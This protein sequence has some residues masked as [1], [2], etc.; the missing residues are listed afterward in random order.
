MM[1]SMGQET[2]RELDAVLEARGAAEGLDF[3]IE[4]FRSERELPLLF[5]ARLMRKRLEL[6]LPLVQTQ[7]PGEFPEELRAAYERAMMEVA[8]EVGNGYLEAGNIPRAWPYFRAI[9]EPGP[10]VAALEKAEPGGDDTDALI[11]IAFE[12]GVHPARGLQMIMSQHGMCRALTSF[13]MHQVAKDRE[14]CIALL[15]KQ[16]HAEVVDRMARTIEAREGALPLTSNLVEMME[17]RDWLFGEY[18]YYVDTSHLLTLVPYSLDVDDVEI[19][20]LMNELCE[21]GKRLAPSFQSR[22]QAPFENICADHGEYCKAMLGLDVDARVAHFRKIAE[23]ADPLMVGTAPAQFLVSLLVRLTRFDEAL[24]VSLQYLGQERDVACP[25]ALQ[26]CRMA[27]DYR[28]LGELAEERG[29]LLSYAAAGIERAGGVKRQA[30][31]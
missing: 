28:R 6:G 15:T 21:Y 22:G 18:D 1:L 5:E 7:D 16:L 19:L 10:V 13:G 24:E 9:G 8:R 3:L 29:D 2:F 30:G 31:D 11:S 23:E 17:G 27:G 4:R 26:L 20:R 25:S 14:E 12:E